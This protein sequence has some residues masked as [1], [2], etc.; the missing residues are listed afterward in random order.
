[1]KEKY[2]CLKCER[3]H[4]LENSQIGWEHRK[5]S[6]EKTYEKI[7]RD[8]EGGSVLEVLK[9]KYPERLIEDL[10]KKGILMFDRYNGQNIIHSCENERKKTE[11]LKMARIG[12]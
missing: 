6:E 12:E 9:G 10:G 1:M 11:L 2:Y 7:Y 8:C 4:K 3:N 5:Y